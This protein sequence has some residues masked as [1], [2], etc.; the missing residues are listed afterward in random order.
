MLLCSTYDILRT[1]TLF[2]FQAKPFTRPCW[3]ACCCIV[4]FALLA[5]TG[6]ACEAPFLPM[7]EPPEPFDDEHSGPRHKTVTDEKEERETDVFESVSP[8]TGRR[9]SPQ[10]AS[11][12][13]VH[14]PA[15]LVVRPS[16]VRRCS[17]KRPTKRPD[18]R[19]LGEDCGAK[20]TRLRSHRAL[21]NRLADVR[22]RVGKARLAAGIG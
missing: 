5:T 2:S 20:R 1:G 17:G 15:M 3:F 8:T 4:A 13:V 22:A 10:V 18:G 7:V 21:A 11:R 19:C 6:L 14:A 16:I 12:G 9:S